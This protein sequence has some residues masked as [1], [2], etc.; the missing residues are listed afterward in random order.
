[1][2]PILSSLMAPPAYSR[3]RLAFSSPW[4]I[5]IPESNVRDDGTITLVLPK[6]VFPG[7]QPG[8]AINVTLASVRATAPSGIPGT[9]GTNETIPDTTGGTSYVLRPA[10]LCL[11]NTAPLASLAANIQTGLQPLAVNFDGS[12]SHDN[13]GIDTIASYTFNF[14]D[15]GDD[16]VQSTPT[17]NHTFNDAGPLRCETGRHR[18][19]R[20]SEQQHRSSIDRCPAAAGRGHGCFP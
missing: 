20:Q 3:A 9:G 19:A 1:M 7:I 4:V 8:Q 10:N 12:A 6:S 13:D 5:S 2:A 16:V 18:F 14:G 11:P 17:I 15:G